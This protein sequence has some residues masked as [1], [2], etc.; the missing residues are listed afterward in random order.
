MLAHGRAREIHQVAVAGNADEREIAGAAAHVADEHQLAVEE[1]LA[2]GGQ[3]VR[4]PRIE[5][6][7]RFFEQRQALNAGFARGH[8]RQL[9]R[10]FVE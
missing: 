7:R 10:L 1:T 5:G 8:H 3:V 6:G 9:A 2:R 4:N